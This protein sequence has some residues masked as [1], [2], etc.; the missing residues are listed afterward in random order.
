MDATLELLHGVG[1]ATVTVAAEIPR[2]H[3]SVAVL[4]SSRF[5]TGSVIDASGLV[6]TVN[7]VVVGAGRVSVVD[8][9]GRRHE[10]ALVAQDY[11]TGVAV[12]RA[13]SLEAPPLA[14]GRSS[15]VERGQ[16]VFLVA[17]VGGNER[18]MNTGVVTSFDAF[19][20]YWEYRLDRALW[21]STANP[22]LG[23][24]PVCNAAGEIVG[25]VS[26]NLGQIGRTTLAIP[27]E[28]FFDHAAEMLAE[29]RRVTRPRR[30]WLG[31]FCHELPDRPV[32]AGVIPGSPGEASGL[33][34]GDVILS[35]DR[36]EVRARTHVYERIWAHGPGEIIEVEI[37]REGTR[38]TFVVE[39][40]DAEEFFS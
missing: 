20:A 3:P 33:Q 11:A 27:A 34:P 1:R 30:A 15:A 22:G 8:V 13:E 35:V 26:L 9:E 31:M 18:R 28:C 4:G 32:V 25:V 37:D 40:G 2:N 6:L 7:Y 21:L 10:A 39:S 24:G 19:D 23:G 36:V 29:G 5:G 17:S 14:P 12:I 38:E 16:D